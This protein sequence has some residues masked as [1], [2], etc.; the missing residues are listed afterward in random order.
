MEPFKNAELNALLGKDGPFPMEFLKRPS[1]PVRTVD[2]VHIIELSLNGSRV[3][4]ITAAGT[5]TTTGWSDA[6]LDPYIYIQPPPDGIWDFVFTARPPSGPAGDV[7]SPIAANYFWL[8]GSFQLKGVR[9][10]S[11]T[12]S[13]TKKI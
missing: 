7:I 10:H 1:Q 11:A 3:A 9:I 13:I 2:H 8:L 6:Q 12:N 4:L 5:V